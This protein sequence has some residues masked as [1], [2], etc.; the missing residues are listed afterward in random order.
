[1]PR[2]PGSDALTPRRAA[3]AARWLIVKEPGA[4]G[5]WLWQGPVNGS[6]FPYIGQDGRS[7]LASRVLYLS[8][9]DVLP[10]RL[11]A[12]CDERRCVKPDHREPV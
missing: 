10:T 9:Y 6:G 3:D 12:T 2:R 7:L 11:R 5:H 8:E 4:Q 1:M